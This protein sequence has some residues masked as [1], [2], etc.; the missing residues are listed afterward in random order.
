MSQE[1]DCQELKVSVQVTEADFIAFSEYFFR[2]TPE[3]KRHMRRLYVL[4]IGLFLLFAGMNYSDPEHG[5]ANPLG[6]SVYLAVSA[7]MMGAFYYVFVH[8]VRSMLARHMVRKGAKRHLLR[9]ATMRFSAD[10]I[11]VENEKGSGFLPW[12]HVTGVAGNEDYVFLLLGGLNAFI[13]RKADLDDAA[14][15]YGTFLDW[16]QAARRAPDEDNRVNAQS[17]ESN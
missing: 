17:G 15:C 3:G 8:Y 16:W 4:G 6:Y 7:L 1:D 10:G 2:G 11:R 13:L 9:P 5:I 12:K 14:T